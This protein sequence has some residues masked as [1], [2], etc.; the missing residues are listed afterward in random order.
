MIGMAMA[1]SA[2]GGT[3][4]MDGAVS[5]FLSPGDDVLVI[6]GGKF[7]E[8]W[9]KICQAYGMK[10]EEVLVEWGYSAKAEQVEA[11]LKKNP[12]IKAVFVQAN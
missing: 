8:R 5:N 7:G 10:V 2:S 6:N 11:A 4:G 12:K 9:T 3:G 1:R